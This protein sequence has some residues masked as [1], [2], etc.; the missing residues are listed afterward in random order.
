MKSSLQIS[1]DKWR[2][3]ED[4]LRIGED[5]LEIGKIGWVNPSICKVAF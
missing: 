2:V 1:G 3:N 4:K 5:K